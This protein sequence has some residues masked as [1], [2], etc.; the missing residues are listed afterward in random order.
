[1]SKNLNLFVC[2]ILLTVGKAQLPNTDL[3]LF[4]LETNKIKQTHLTDP[5]NIT[6]RDGYDNQPSFSEDGKRIYYVSIHEDKQA[7]IYFY[8]IA[9]K[10]NVAFTKTR[11]SEYSP[12]LTEGGMYLASVVVEAD[13]AQRIHYIN[14]VSG[15]DEKKLDMDSVGYF[16]LLNSDTVVYYKLTE[17]HS[18]RYYVKSSHEDKWLANS[19]VRTFKP[20]NRHK[21]IYGLKDSAKVCFYTYD[22]L[23]RKASRYAEYPSTSEDVIWHPQYG[24]VKS[25]ENRLLHFDESKNEWVLL[26]DL[27]SF[28]IKKITRFVFDPKNKFLV[29]VNNL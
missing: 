4:K 15:L 5:L 26:Y 7:D 18:L 29:V 6:S 12:T 8:D 19:P 16:A 22:F 11:V 20:I 13:S 27:G 23:L 10:K 28:G 25:E 24:L 17:P 2:I 21:L 9:T 3:W 1:M 14:T